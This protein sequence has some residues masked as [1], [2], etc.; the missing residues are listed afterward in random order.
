MGGILMI[1]GSVGSVLLFMW[2]FLP[3]VASNPGGLDPPA[4]IAL[5]IIAALLIPLVA[6]SIV[7]GVAA[8]RR[9]SYRMAFIGGICSVICSTIIGLIGLILV[10]RSKDEFSQPDRKTVQAAP[11]W[12]KAP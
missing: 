3:V 10:I 6:G 2:V 12:P 5:V 8:I 1:V 7:G 11:N 4:V 9:S